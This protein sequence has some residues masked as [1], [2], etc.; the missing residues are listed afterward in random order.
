[1]T[2]RY[3]AHPLKVSDIISKEEEKKIAQDILQ[4]PP[5]QTKFKEYLPLF[6]VEAACGNFGDGVAVQEAG[7]VR[8]DIG[9]TLNRRM[10]VTRVFGKSMEPLIPDG[11]YCVFSAGIVGSR[12]NKIVLVQSNTIH[13][14]DNG[15]KYTVKKYTSKKRATQNGS[16]EHE[17]IALMPLNP[18]YKP[19]IISN[20][21]EGEFMVIAEFIAV[22][23]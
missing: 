6:T 19:I 2:A 1:M 15:G 4:S 7:W 9:K 13:D 20:A 8:V 10:F 12:N 22:L 17:E 16:W 14:S 23:K 21:D 5:E 11:S 18:N 3:E